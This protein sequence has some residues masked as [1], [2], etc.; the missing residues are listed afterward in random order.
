MRQRATPGRTN[1]TGGNNPSQLANRSASSAPD[2]NSGNAI[3]PSVNPVIAWSAILSRLMPART[4]IPMPS[5]TISTTATAASQ[6]C[7]AHDPK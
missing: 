4:P 2:T 5:G 3:A 7:Y 1:D 6:T